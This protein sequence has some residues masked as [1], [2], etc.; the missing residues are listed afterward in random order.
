M[1]SDAD[2]VV[3]PI[4]QLI[5]LSLGE[6]THFQLGTRALNKQLQ[7]QQLLFYTSTCVNQH[8][9]LRTEGFWWRNVYCLH[10]L[11]DGN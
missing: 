8:L 2:C 5:E 1:N 10:A 7:Q 6:V 11:A 3:K 9:Q 4:K